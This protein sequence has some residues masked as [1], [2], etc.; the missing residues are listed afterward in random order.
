M[1]N[2]KCTHI[3]QLRLLF[4][5]PNSELPDVETDD[6]LFFNFGFEGVRQTSTINARNLQLPA[7]ALALAKDG[8]LADLKE[9]RYC[10]G[11]KDASMCDRDNEAASEII[12]PECFCTHVVDVDPNRSIQL[13]ISAIGPDP[14]D[15]TNF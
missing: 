7:V 2:T 8:E 14:M 13:V 6:K 1:Y 4:P 15:L 10:K 9:N 3:H 11:L 5:L 12:S